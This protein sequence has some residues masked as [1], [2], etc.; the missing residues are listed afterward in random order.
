[1]SVREFFDALDGHVASRGG[2]KGKGGA[3]PP[4]GPLVRRELNALMAQFPD[5]PAE[6]QAPMLSLSP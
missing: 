3:A 5:E 4:G 2:G 6:A 1:M